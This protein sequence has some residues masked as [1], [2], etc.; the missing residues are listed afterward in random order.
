MCEVREAW[1]RREIS[2]RRV[3]SNY[4]MWHRLSG[5]G[6]RGGAAFVSYPHISGVLSS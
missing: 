2:E 5:K 4:M 1:W 3:V 6:G